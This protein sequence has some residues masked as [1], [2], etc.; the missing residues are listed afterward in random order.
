METAAVNR[1]MG[2]TDMNAQSSRSHSIF[3]VY[4]TGTNADLGAT[5]TGCLHLC[6]LAGP[7]APSVLAFRA[8]CAWDRCL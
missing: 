5:V 2:A 7:P 4:L 8:L 3:T 6:D 1:A